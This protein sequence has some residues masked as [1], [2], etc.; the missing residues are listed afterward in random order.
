MTYIGII[1]AYNF[2]QKE[3]KGFKMLFH[4]YFRQFFLVHIAI[5]TLTSSLILTSQAS[6]RMQT[7]QSL[8]KIDIHGQSGFPKHWKIFIEKALEPVIRDRAQYAELS[9]KQG[10]QGQ[11]LLQIKTVGYRNDPELLGDFD[12]TADNPTNLIVSIYQI[13][14]DT[15]PYKSVAIPS[16]KRKSLPILHRTQNSP[17]LIGSL[18]FSTGDLS[19]E[20]PRWAEIQKSLR[21]LF[22]AD[23]F[24]H[25]HSNL[26]M[27]LA[28]RAPQQNLSPPQQY[29]IEELLKMDA[30]F[31]SDNEHKGP[32]SIILQMPVGTGKTFTTSEYLRRLLDEGRLNKTKIVVVYQNVMAL[33]QLEEF[34]KKVFK[35]GK[36]RVLSLYNGITKSHSFPDTLDD[37]DLILSSRSSYY[38]N[39]ARLHKLI[40]NEKDANWFYFFDEMHHLGK[41]DGEFEAIIQGEDSTP[42]LNALLGKNDR[43]LYVS[44]TPW[45]SQKHLISELVQG[46]VIAP[47]LSPEELA[48]LRN[49][50]PENLAQHQLAVIELART[51]MFRAIELGYLAPITHF[52]LSGFIGQRPIAD[53]LNDTEI[54][55][56]PDKL[57]KQLTIHQGVVD[58]I[59]ERIIANREE[60]QFDHGLIYVPT[61]HH[62]NLYSS[63]LNRYFE[64]KSI[65]GEFRAYHSKIQDRD[66]EESWFLSSSG[67]KHRY[68]LVVDAVKEA[69][70]IPMLNLIVNAR[71]IH[72]FKTLVQIFGR[73]SRPFVGKTG[74]R[75]IDL[76]GSFL[77]LI[78]P[79]AKANIFANGT[80][81]PQIKDAEAYSLEKLVG[82]RNTEVKTTDFF[83][84]VLDFEREVE[85]SNKQ[86][87]K[88][89][90]TLEIGFFQNLIKLKR[91]LQLVKTFKRLT[92]QKISR[93]NSLDEDLHIRTQKR[94]KLNIEL[95]RHS[96][97]EKSIES[98]IKYYQTR[99][100]DYSHWPKE[101]WE[102]FR[103]LIEEEGLKVPHLAYLD[104][105]TNLDLDWIWWFMQTLLHTQEGEE[106]SAFLKVLFEESQRFPRRRL[107]DVGPYPYKVMEMVRG[108]LQREKNLN[109][110]KFRQNFL[111]AL[112]LIVKD[113]GKRQQL[114]KQMHTFLF[115]ERRKQSLVNNMHAYNLTIAHISKIEG[116]DIALI[117]FFYN[118]LFPIS[119]NEQFEEH[120]K[121]YLTIITS[122]SSSSQ[123]LY[124]LDSWLLAEAL[125]KW[126]QQLPPEIF[127]KRFSGHLFEIAAKHPH[128][129]AKILHQ[130]HLWQDL[131]DMQI[132]FKSLM[133]NS[134][135]A[136]KNIA[137][138][139]SQHPESCPH[140]FFD[141]GDNLI[142]PFPYEADRETTREQERLHKNW[143][144]IFA[145]QPMIPDLVLSHLKK[146]LS[147]YLATRGKSNYTL[148]EPI[149]LLELISRG[150]PAYENA[151][152]ELWTL[153]EQLPLD[154]NNKM[155]KMLMEII[156]MQFQK[157]KPYPI[158]LARKIDLQIDPTGRVRTAF[159]NDWL[160]NREGILSEKT[161]G[162]LEANSCEISLREGEH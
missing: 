105:V 83:P 107:T 25:D 85:N 30:S 103:L 67:K 104:H 114:H 27:Q 154:D 47:F 10:S 40:E 111:N 50:H 80:T 130:T 125:V 78:H 31:A 113:E 143:L 39:L 73:G 101:E 64:N 148:I 12:R 137:D 92:Q 84:K 119:S 76:T 13:V 46:G 62:A 61:I 21:S 142:A 128:F 51:Q 7:L 26:S 150:S 57:Q 74:L 110:K 155:Y 149:G 5:L 55:E 100:V 131:P 126:P 87:Q 102:D 2:N 139:Y 49:Y 157:G 68:W 115:E 91:K 42:G 45:H 99:L 41:E 9:L 65:E 29:A 90:H 89:R 28:E 8:V 123:D 63:L 59:A 108:T 159:V 6:T 116:N 109:I 152:P 132:T 95:V 75:L 96:S 120:L 79:S 140:F 71:L 118:Q 94:Q 129:L 86:G 82:L 97:E 69:I 56:T 66:K 24:L 135:K 43:T 141:L 112:F 19:L 133:K 52:E 17:I 138:Y 3:S 98:R 1:I 136:S 151:L 16:L 122:H 58:H 162:Q 106:R 70:D 15:S 117:Q 38:K 48:Q 147:R 134:V 18:K 22:R 4:F 36:D 32:V 34:F 124:W 35:I 44:A 11:T 77:Y 20:D 81:I 53:I 121:R 127:T 160:N 33:K 161:Q 93:L 54:V 146:Y 144:S 23:P 88:P 14:V 153:L 156:V 60:S 158:E 37:F 72:D 145:N